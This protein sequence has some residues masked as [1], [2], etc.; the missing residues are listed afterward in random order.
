MIGVDEAGRG[1]WA[2][3]LVA[4]AVSFARGCGL[5]DRLRDSKK[6]T[7]GQRQALFKDLT[8]SEQIDFGVAMVPAV[9]IDRYGLTWAQTEA[10]SR[11]VS[12]IVADSQARI[13]VDGSVNYLKGAYPNAAA[14]TKA[15]NKIAEVM[16]ASIIAKVTRDNYMAGLKKDY[17]G[18]CF[19]RHKGYG[20]LRHRRAIRELSAIKGIHRLSYR[21][22][23]TP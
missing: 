15:D 10:M 9:D 16:A 12:R 1:A 2:G 7:A 20:T 14:V 22:F 21:P 18:Y 6:L 4:A 5:K 11:A 19:E 17:P 3:P 23:Q 8:E 13:I